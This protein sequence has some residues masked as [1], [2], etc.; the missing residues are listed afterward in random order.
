[1][2]VISEEAFNPLHIAI[3]FEGEEKGDDSDDTHR[4]PYLKT[5]GSEVGVGGS[6]TQHQ[7]ENTH[8]R[9]DNTKIYLHTLSLF[10]KRSIYKIGRLPML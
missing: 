2:S 9:Q 6:S 3:F 8:R 7:Q 5:V 10:F 4:H 1:M